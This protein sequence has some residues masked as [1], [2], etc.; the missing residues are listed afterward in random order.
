[1]M[2]AR[3]SLFKHAVRWLP[4]LLCLCVLVVSCRSAHP[5]SRAVI[6]LGVIELSDG[7]PSER[8]YLGAGKNVMVTATVLHEGRLDLQVDLY[9]EQIGGTQRRL[10]TNHV[11]THPDQPTVVPINAAD[12]K[13]I[14]HLKGE[15]PK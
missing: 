4:L 3:N 8:F 5:K 12:F 2:T 1:M 7:V 14:P 11:H 13:I 9:Q 6:Y 15:R 10:A